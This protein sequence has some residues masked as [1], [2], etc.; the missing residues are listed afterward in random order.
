MFR[1]KKS[2]KKSK[3]NINKKS[4][5]IWK[6]ILSYTGVLLLP[7]LICSFYY[8]HSYNILEK[9]ILSNQ[10][11]ILENYRKQID[12]VFYDVLNLSNY[13]QLNHYISSIAQGKS[14][15][16]SA[17][18]LDR[19]YLRDD[20]KL[21]KISNSLIQQINVFFP[22]SGYIVTDSSSFE[23]AMLP[24][25]DSTQIKYQDWAE[26]SKKLKECHI[27][28]KTTELYDCLLIAKVLR[29]D[30]Q[31]NPRAI[32]AVQLDKDSLVE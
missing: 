3:I 14:S 2:V 18:A 8:F 22:E 24:L 7:I 32:M 19:H 17:P 9:R 12:S 28:C 11:L 16:G 15:F 23:I 5:I 27:I 13:L 6:W 29:T 26:I 4:C 30:I 20:L 31:G 10:H 25:M 1:I 21:L